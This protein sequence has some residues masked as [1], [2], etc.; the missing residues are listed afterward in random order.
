MKQRPLQDLQDRFGI[1][2]PAATRVWEELRDKVKR[3]YLCALEGDE[4]PISEGSR[5][6]NHILASRFVPPKAGFLD[7][8]KRIVETYGEL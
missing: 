8:R 7:I 4:L 2:R 3:L 1:S 5:E 6:L